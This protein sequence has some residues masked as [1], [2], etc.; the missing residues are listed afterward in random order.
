[1]QLG[2]ADG[3]V[4]SLLG[5]V[6]RER[7]GQQDVEEHPG[8]PHVHWL[9]VRLPLNHLGAHEVRGSYPAC[10]SDEERVR[11]RGRGHTRN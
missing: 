8:R 2:L 3:V 4:E 5:A 6:E 7:A 1:M 9:P 10:G 11:A